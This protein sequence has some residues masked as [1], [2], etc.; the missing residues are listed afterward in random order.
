[1]KTENDSE[2]HLPKP[3]LFL[4]FSSVPWWVLPWNSFRTSRPR[5]TGSNLVFHRELRVG[6]FWWRKWGYHGDI[7]G[8]TWEYDLIVLIL[9]WICH[10]KT[11]FHRKSWGYLFHQRPKLGVTENGGFHLWKCNFSQENDDGGIWRYT[12]F[13]GTRIWYKWVVWQNCPTFLSLCSHAHRY[14]PIHH[15]L[16]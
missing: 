2:N 16:I 11:G 7:M 4:S 1:M 8:I 3:L 5:G 12:I 14:I 15:F 6:S 13:R 9:D 10:Q